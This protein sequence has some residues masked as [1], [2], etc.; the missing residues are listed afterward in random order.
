MPTLTELP[1][2]VGEMYRRDA[3]AAI[4]AHKAALAEAGYVIVPQEPTGKM[5]DSACAASPRIAWRAMVE[6]AG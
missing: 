3:R 5:L 1:P 6:A 4:E 2:G